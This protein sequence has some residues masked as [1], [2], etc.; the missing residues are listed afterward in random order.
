MKQVFI[1]FKET[2][3]L[4]T[5]EEFKEKIFDCESYV[6][7]DIGVRIVTED[8]QLTFTWGSINN[9]EELTGE[10]KPFGAIP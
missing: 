5:G 6:F 4:R 8:S 10:A 9:I 1:S 2:Q 3:K 7:F